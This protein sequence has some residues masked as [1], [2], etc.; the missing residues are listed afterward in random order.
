MI[1]VGALRA[2]RAVAALG[3]LARAADELGFTASAVSQQIKRLERQVGVPVLAPA[4]RGVVLTPAGR[5]IVDAAPEVFQAL[6]RCAEAA[7]SAS[8]GLPR[9]VLRVVAFSTGIRGLLAPAVARLAERH[10]DLRVDIT[11]QDPDQA[12]HSVD[13]GTADLALVHD[14][15]GLPVAVAP[16]STRRHV[17]TD[18][19][20]VVVR[21]DHPLAHLDRP[22]TG[23]DLAGHAWVTSPPGTVCHQWFRRLFA[24]APQAPDVRHLIDDFATQLSLVDSGQVIALIPRLARPPLHDGLRARP[25]SRPPRR[26]VHAAWRRSADASP[27][28]RAVLAALAEA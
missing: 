19:G 9:G 7:Q 4:G 26:E 3:T 14:A 1:E 18:T 5:A 28:I 16:T 13:A 2:L 22:L 11:E 27:A 17:H 15:D 23:A 12:L 6:E 25:L 21:H 10:P 20:D 24:D 8:T